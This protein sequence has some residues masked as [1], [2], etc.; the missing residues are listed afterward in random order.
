ML[1]DKQSIGYWVWS[2]EM[3]IVEANGHSLLVPV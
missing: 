1:I 3:Y 2:I